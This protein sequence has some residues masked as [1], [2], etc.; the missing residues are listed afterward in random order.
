MAD[1][2]QNAIKFLTRHSTFYGDL[3]AHAGSLNIDGANAFDFAF[4]FNKDLF[5][6]FAS[7]KN[8]P[9]DLKAIREKAM[10]KDVSKEDKFA[11][12]ITIFWY[13]MV[14]PTKPKGEGTTEILKNT[15]TCVRHTITRIDIR[16][17]GE[18]RNRKDITPPR[19]LSAFP[20]VASRAQAQVPESLQILKLPSSLYP[21]SHPQV[22][23]LLEIDETSLETVNFTLWSCAKTS[24]ILKRNP[25]ASDQTILKLME[26]QRMYFNLAFGSTLVPKSLRARARMELGSDDVIRTHEPYNKFCRD[27]LVAMS[28]ITVDIRYAKDSEA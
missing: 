7:C 17:K 15:F 23:A 12:M 22:A 11:T 19:L 5:D 21:Y 6:A 9:V 24:A 28:A 18:Q 2:L 8:V 26:E 14:G 1:L 27:N 25:D 13:V 20:E 4:A 16:H 3:F 10:G